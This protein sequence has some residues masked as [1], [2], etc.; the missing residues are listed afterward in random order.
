MPFCQ[1]IKSN[2]KWCR[3]YARKGLTCCWSHRKLEN[4]KEA[5]SEFEVTVL[6]ETRVCCGKTSRRTNCPVKI[7]DTCLEIDNKWFCWIHERNI[8]DKFRF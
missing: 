7:D 1:V 2:D 8:N 5:P 6:V 3:N 4:D